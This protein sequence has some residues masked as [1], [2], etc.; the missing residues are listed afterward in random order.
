[1]PQ[2]QGGASAEAFKNRWYDLCGL[3]IN[4]ILRAALFCA[5]S[6][7][8]PVHSIFV[9]ILNRQAIVTYIQ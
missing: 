7:V 2:R 1:M 5:I 6:M 4:Y 8:I 3:D 9:R